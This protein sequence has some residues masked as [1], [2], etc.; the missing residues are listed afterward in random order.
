MKEEEIGAAAAVC[1]YLAI[2]GTLVVGWIMN[3]MTIWHTLD[4]PLTAKLILR[5]IGVFVFP[6]GGILGY[7]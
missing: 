7:L 6:V 4:G 2:A 1:V 5:C 3:I